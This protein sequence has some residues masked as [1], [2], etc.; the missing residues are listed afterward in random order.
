MRIARELLLILT[1]LVIA[2]V[3][4]VQASSEQATTPTTDLLSDSTAPNGAKAVYLWL[5]TLGYRVERMEYREFEF[6]HGT[7]VLLVLAPSNRPLKDELTTMRR[8]VEDGGTLIVAASA[9]SP[10]AQLPGIEPSIA[11][12]ASAAV[13]DE[14]GIELRPLPSPQ[15]DSAPGQPLLLRPAVSQARV[16]ASHFIAGSPRLVPY[17]G[18]PEHP[19][20]ASLEVGQ[21]RVYVLASTYALSNQGLDNADNAALLLNWLPPPGDAGVVAFDEIHHGRSDV[22]PL[23]YYLVREPWGWALLYALGVAFLYLALD[24]R[25]FG[26]A[27][28]SVVDTRRSAAEYVVSVADLLRRGGKSSWAARHY[29]R[30]L[31]R[32]LAVACGLEVTLETAALATRLNKVDQVTGGVTGRE[33]REVLL[34]LDD[35]ASKGISEDRLVQ[36]AAKADRII[37]S[38]GG[39]Q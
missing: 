17:L 11:G 4:A 5:E 34:E 27:V 1:P 32:Q 31:R 18:D 14:F 24:G 20:A 25:R 37:K 36:L 7:G 29:E 21:G 33:A 16:E 8:W 12:D 22:R 2:A 26:R 15:V 13:L 38:C 6:D 19:V 30:R 28:P 35:G 9:P 3:I 23:P 10:L 39:R